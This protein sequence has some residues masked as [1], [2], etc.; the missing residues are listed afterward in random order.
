[1][2]YLGIGVV[3]VLALVREFLDTVKKDQELWLKLLEPISILKVE[4]LLK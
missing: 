1:M 4:I 2:E 3:M